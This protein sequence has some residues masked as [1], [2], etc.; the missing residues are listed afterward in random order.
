MYHDFHTSHDVLDA[1]IVVDYNIHSIRHY[2]VMPHA[3]DNLED[4]RPEN[5][6]V[7]D[8]ASQEK[9]RDFENVHCL[10]NH[11]DCCLKGKDEEDNARESTDVDVQEED[12]SS[13]RVDKN[14]VRGAD[15]L[16]RV[17]LNDIDAILESV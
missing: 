14:G 15:V 1:A 11:K 5:G 16:S 12:Y 7:D 10:H 9:R 2:C 8:N 13:H 3:I 6:C 17:D 4:A